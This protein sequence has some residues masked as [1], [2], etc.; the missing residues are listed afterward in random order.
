MSYT[1]VS[2]KSAYGIVR[3]L[4]LLSAALPLAMAH[5]AVAQNL[6]SGAP[7]Q[8]VPPSGAIPQ[9]APPPGAMPPSGF[10]QGG[11]P[12]GGFPQG[13]PPLPP[14]RPHVDPDTI[15]EKAVY[16]DA[17]ALEL[18]LSEDPPL[19][20]AQKVAAAL[21]VSPM[22]AMAEP[23]PLRSDAARSSPDPR[24]FSGV[25][26]HD[27]SLHGRILRD[28]HGKLIP[29]TMEGA[30]VLERRFK[31]DKAGRPY[32]NGAALCRPPGIVWQADVH[33]PF[34]VFQSKGAV[35]FVFQDYRG[36]LNFV[37]DD[38]LQPSGKSYMG[39]ALAHWDGDTLV[40]ETS[41]FKQ[42]LWLDIA[43]TPV[44]KDARLINR[45]RKIDNGDHK[46]LLEIETTIVDPKYYTDPWTLV[47]TF[48]WQPN[49]PLFDEYNCELQL[50]DPNVNSDAGLVPEPSETP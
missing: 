2:R 11:P 32:Q 48:R 28:M 37:L 23:P 9:G 8:G 27:L 18:R 24:D 5:G 30:R 35:E 40:A 20:E 36:R 10:P 13:G 47:R 22:A 33:M 41:G 25:W 3:S 7:T 21:P 26:F 50:G 17:A 31:A 34:M 45:V 29:F 12:L 44:S 38:K 43:G 4:R 39:T 46:P 14:A 6:P 49:M 1:S 15:P 19:T 16:A 42:G